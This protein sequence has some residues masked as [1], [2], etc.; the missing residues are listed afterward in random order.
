MYAQFYGL[1]ELPF[2][3]TGSPRYLLLTSTHAEG[4]SVLQYG[5]STRKGIIVLVAE[6]GTG[7]TILLRAALASQPAGGRFVLITN[8]LLTR[9]EFFQQLVQGFCLS[10]QAAASKTQFLS[11]LT[12]ILEGYKR[13]GARTGLIVDEAHLL[14]PE[15]FE[16]IRLL[17]NLESS[18]GTLLPIVLA[19]QPELADRLN[20]RDR[21]ALKQR[22]ALRCSVAPLR[23]SETSAYIEGRIKMAGGNG[24]PVFAPETVELIHRC[25]NGVPRTINVICDNALVAGF[26]TYERPISRQTVLEVCRDLDLA[27]PCC[28]G[29][30]AVVAARPP[31][32][33]AVARTGSFRSLFL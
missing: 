24:V 31:L 14:S 29:R 23:F 4:L 17:A 26:A 11:E 3:I 10:D 25:S 1:Q 20:E 28:E 22:V 2:S 7:K 8:P 19:G 16:E 30:E 32:D 13:G 9:S 6:A 18:D 27:I 12:A 15:I 21:R 33:A 5:L